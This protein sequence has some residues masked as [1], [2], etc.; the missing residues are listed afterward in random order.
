LRDV[1][2]EAGGFEMDARDDNPDDASDL[3]AMS[4][5]KN[6]S[7]VSRRHVSS[8]DWSAAPADSILISP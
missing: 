8:C 1:R 3:I 2:R 7:P 5:A 4:E 6:P